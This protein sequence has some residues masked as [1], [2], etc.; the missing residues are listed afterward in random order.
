MKNLC[1]ELTKL[2]NFLT[3]AMECQQPVVNITLS[4]DTFNAILDYRTQQAVEAY[5]AEQ[6]Q[7][8][9]EQD[10][11]DLITPKETKALLHGISDATLWRY[12]KS[13][14]VDKKQVGGKVY[15]SRK[16]LTKLMEG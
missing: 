12:V 14:L 6:E 11:G 5:E 2:N 8:R 1:N 13:G 16:Q 4:A 10:N 3:A 7:Q 9:K 15:Y